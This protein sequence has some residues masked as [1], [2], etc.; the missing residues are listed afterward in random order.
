MAR[1][2]NFFELVDLY[3][4]N[5]LSG[6]Q[7]AAFKREL[8]VNEE[9]AL[10]LRLQSE[11]AESVAETDVMDLRSSLKELR[12]H[13]TSFEEE[14]VLEE[15][16]SFGLS[17]E[18]SFLEEM[19]RTV[20]K[21]DI[22]EIDNSLHKLHFDQHKKAET[23]SVHDMYK[24]EK[25]QQKGQNVSESEFDD[26]LFDDIGSAIAEQDI[27]E[28][29]S[30]LKNIAQSIPQHQ[31]DLETIE[32]YIDGELPTEQYQEFAA[33]LEGN[34]GLIDDVDLSR[35]INT[36][37]SEQEVMDLRASLREIGDQ[38]EATNWNT[39]KIEEYISDSLDESEHHEFERELEYN[40]DLS[41]EVALHKEV[42]QAIAESD[43]MQLRAT[44]ND[45]RNT[46]DLLPEKRSISQLPK[47][48]RRVWSISAACIVLMLGVVGAL[49]MMHAPSDAELFASYYTK[50]E[51]SGV[52]SGNAETDI[53]FKM[54]LQNYNDNSYQKAASQ[55]E[56]LLKVD[57]DVSISFYAA[58]SYQELQD[59][60]K[61][62]NHFE[63]VINDGDNLFIEQSQ[64]YLGLCYLNN[65]D[66][67]RAVKYFELVAQNGKSHLRKKAKRIIK[68]LR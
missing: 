16:Y 30:G 22:D 24:A 6:E 36:A 46:E 64:W 15:E 11:V 52:R 7:L 40:I 56:Q 44:L 1:K 61:A 45:I 31:Y 58:L 25:E 18:I 34:I 55:F 37:I 62:I 39:D 23:E 21:L 68:I 17:D 54:A 10:E 48:M 26:I 33:E 59:F 28:L 8:R 50:Y 12:D 2:N 57:Q 35:E 67:K 29:R 47:R 3:L 41:N 32:D 13:E 4:N 20:S 63:A 14:V 66:R 43:V 60:D 27:I 19:Q 49:R 65:D 9:L 5:E 51:I 42:D 53:M 38:R